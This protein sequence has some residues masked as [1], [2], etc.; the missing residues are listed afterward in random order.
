L[1]SGQDDWLKFRE[2]IKENGNKE[3]KK[4]EETKLTLTFLLRTVYIG[5][6]KMFVY[7]R[8]LDTFIANV[9]LAG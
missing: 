4:N 9:N 6:K 2:I 1:K 8:Q 5:S 3:K 7:P